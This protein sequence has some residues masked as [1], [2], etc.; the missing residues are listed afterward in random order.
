MENTNTEDISV[1][2]EFPT[3]SETADVSARRAGTGY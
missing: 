1:V 3:S 2:S